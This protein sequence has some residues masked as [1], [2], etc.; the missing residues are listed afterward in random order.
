MT[1]ST[2]DR[3]LGTSLWRLSGGLAH[4]IH[5]SVGTAALT[6]DEHRAQ[7]EDTAHMTTTVTE[8]PRLNRSERVGPS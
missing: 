1:S 3:A 8:T 5:H 4:E 6:S 2:T 7:G